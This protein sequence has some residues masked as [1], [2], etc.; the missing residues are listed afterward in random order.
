M[1]VGDKFKFWEDVWVGNN[2]L[3]SLYPRLHSI[4]LD[5]GLMVGE[6]GEWEDSI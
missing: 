4:S 1:G 5:Q 3:M 2:M 6:V